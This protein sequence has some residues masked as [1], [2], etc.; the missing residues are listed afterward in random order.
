MQFKP[1]RE[2]TGLGNFDALI[3]AD[4]NK[5]VFTPR[6][7]EEIN[8]HFQDNPIVGQGNP[9]SFSDEAQKEIDNYFKDKPKTP[10]SNTITTPTVTTPVYTPQTSINT[11]VV[12]KAP[13]YTPQ[14]SVNTLVSQQQS[15]ESATPQKQW[16]KGLTN[17]Q[18]GLIGFGILAG[19]ATVIIVVAKK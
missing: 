17:M 15:N 13:V 14:T 4:D 1:N 11:P 18:T 8:N 10:V 19:T 6:T 3:G 16:I 9:P 5:P 2:I 7:Q 12:Q